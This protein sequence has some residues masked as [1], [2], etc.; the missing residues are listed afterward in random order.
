M[1]ALLLVAATLPGQYC[2]QCP[3]GGQFQAPPVSYSF[4]PQF[5]FQGGGFGGGFQPQPAYYGGFGQ[6]VPFGGGGCN[7][8]QFRPSFSLQASPGMLTLGATAGGFG[9]GYG[10]GSSPIQYSYPSMPPQTLPAQF[11]GQFAGG[12][13]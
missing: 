9:S 4:S 2:P 7:G 5:N 6:P 8:G 1:N 13:R 11:A 10:A 12:P 3:Q